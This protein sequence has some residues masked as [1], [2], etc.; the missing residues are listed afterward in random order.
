MAVGELN[1]SVN[2]F[3]PIEGPLSF[4]SP[5]LQRHGYE[6]GGREKEKKRETER[7]RLK[8]CHLYPE[9]DCTEVNYCLAEN[10]HFCE[11]LKTNS[12]EIDF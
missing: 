5:V 4:P 8:M 7:E 10:Y 3:L 11:I 9:N 12:C 1:R 6:K 2:F